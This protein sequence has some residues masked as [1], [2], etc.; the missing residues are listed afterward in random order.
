MKDW[1]KQPL[2]QIV[3]QLRKHG[4]DAELVKPR[5]KWFVHQQALEKPCSSSH[6]I[7]L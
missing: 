6:S 2:K 5:V 1:Q 3:E 7:S 4:V